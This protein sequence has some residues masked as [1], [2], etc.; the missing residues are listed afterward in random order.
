MVVDSVFLYMIQDKIVSKYNF[1]ALSA[2][3]A[4]S[5]QQ[6]ATNPH[7]DIL[8]GCYRDIQSFSRTRFQD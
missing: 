1:L 4:C 6:F 2:G 3:I 7:R 5:L 8:Q